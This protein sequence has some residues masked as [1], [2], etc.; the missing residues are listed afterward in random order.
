M[1]GKVSKV[2]LKHPFGRRAIQRVDSPLA[3][4]FVHA[5]LGG[6][7]IEGTD[8]CTYLFSR[9]HN[10]MKND[11]LKRQVIGIERIICVTLLFL[12]HCF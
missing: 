5:S 1:P 4:S 7:S 6:M 10:C 3:R 8:V 11:K 2:F 9:L 12:S